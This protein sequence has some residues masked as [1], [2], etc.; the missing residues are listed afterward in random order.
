MTKNALHNVYGYSP[1]QLVFGCTSNFPSV[2]INKPP[3]L[4]GSTMSITVGNH[5]STLHLARTTFTQSECSERIRRALLKHIHPCGVQY[6]TGD[7]VTT[8]G[9]I[10]LSGKDKEHLSA[11]MELFSSSGMGEL[12]FVSINVDCLRQLFFC[13]STPNSDP[14]EWKPPMVEQ[15]NETSELAF[16]MMRNK[17]KTNIW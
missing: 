5:I 17:M 12:M 7:K 8:N 3:A 1:C 9:R 13:D 16:L 2:L 11:R 10:A 4:E 6:L 15:H 14:T